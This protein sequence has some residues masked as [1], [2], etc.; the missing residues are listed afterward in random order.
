MLT[1]DL[2]PITCTLG[3]RFDCDEAHKTPNIGGDAPLAIGVA[4]DLGQERRP[5][6][7]E[8]LR[9]ALCIGSKT[10]QTTML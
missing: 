10:F 2:R 6:I 9:V 8:G 7:V 1:V 3:R 5:T 4:G